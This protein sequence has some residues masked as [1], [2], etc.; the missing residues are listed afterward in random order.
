M[1][2]MKRVLIVLQL[3]CLDNGVSPSVAQKIADRVAGAF[4]DDGLIVTKQVSA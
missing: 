4:A 3:A 2:S 1:E